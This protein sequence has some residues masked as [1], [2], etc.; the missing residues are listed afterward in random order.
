[1]VPLV[2]STQQTLTW[3]DLIRSL[4][5]NKQQFILSDW[6]TFS[7][8]ANMQAVETHGPVVSCYEG[9]PEEPHL[10]YLPSEYNTP[11]DLSAMFHAL[12]NMEFNLF[13]CDYSSLWQKNAQMDINEM[14]EA[15][16]LALQSVCEW[17]DKN[18]RKGP[19]VVMGGSIGSALAIHAAACLCQR[20][21]C[22]IVESGFDN[23]AALFQKMGKETTGLPEDPF[24]N[25]TKM[26]TYTKPVLFLHSS[27]DEYTTI[28]QVE[29]LVMESRSK[30]TQFQIVPSPSRT[31]MFSST[32]EFYLQTLKDFI[33]L[34]IGR[35]PKLKRH[36][37]Q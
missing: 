9:N 17:M 32:S 33:Y 22:L 28:T 31:N 2:N 11:V 7:F 15:V 34:R 29:W 23:T 30:A 14:C 16:T 8:D 1:M 10:F 19:L 24:A 21:A 4:F 26:R 3:N 35:R 12:K 6:K 20:T 27:R 13:C 18:D 36:M 25:R 5:Q 37:K